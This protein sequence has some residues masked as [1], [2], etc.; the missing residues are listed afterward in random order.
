MEYHNTEDLL[1]TL[2]L[3]DDYA[4]GFERLKPQ[5]LALLGAGRTV[6]VFQNAGLFAWFLK[7]SETLIQ[8]SRKKDMRLLKALLQLKESFVKPESTAYKVLQGSG[9]SCEEIRYLNFVLVDYLHVSCNVSAEGIIGEK[10]AV[11]FCK[12]LLNSPDVHSQHIYHVIN[13]VFQMYRTFSIKCY[14]YQ[15]MKDVLLKSASVQNPETF[16]QTYGFLGRDCISAFDILDGTWDIL[17]VRME[18]ETYIELFDDNLIQIEDNNLAQQWMD[19]F[20]A[21][22]NENYILTFKANFNYNRWPVFKY[23]IQRSFVRLE[24]LFF[25]DLENISDTN[26]E[27]ALQTAEYLTLFLERPYV[28]GISDEAA[29]QVHELLIRLAEEKADELESQLVLSRFYQNMAEEYFLTNYYLYIS[30]SKAGEQYFDSLDGEAT[31]SEGGSYKNNL[32][33]VKQT[34]DT[35]PIVNGGKK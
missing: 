5:I 19:R 1:F 11:E 30:R 2:S 6:S 32:F 26:E 13:Q 15:N 21:L 17:A 20:Q 18:P 27:P 28:A 34:E 9:Y 16:L 29:A 25:A 12:D 3:F 7:Q 33:L 35:Y 8:Q 24:E 23:L 4:T 31:I 22:T 10:I 14:G